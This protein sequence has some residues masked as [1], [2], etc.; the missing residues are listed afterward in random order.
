VPRITSTESLADAT[1]II[2]AVF[3]NVE[4]E[5][6]SVFKLGAEILGL[7][8]EES[9]K[10]EDV[11]RLALVCSFFRDTLQRLP[12]LF[13]AVCI[14]TRPQNSRPPSSV[15][16]LY[17]YSIR[18]S[19]HLSA[20][21]E[22]TMKVSLAVMINF[23]SPD[24][25]DE[26]DEEQ[27]R[28]DALSMLSILCRHSDRWETLVI[29][30]VGLF[31]PD[32]LDWQKMLPGPLGNLKRLSLRNNI[33]PMMES[34]KHWLPQIRVLHV[35]PLDKD[36]LETLSEAPWLLNIHDLILKCD[37]DASITSSTRKLLHA[38]HTLRS[39]HIDGARGI[40]N[41]FKVVTLNSL[42]ELTLNG[43]FPLTRLQA[44]A[45]TSLT[46]NDKVWL[47]RYDPDFPDSPYPCLRRLSIVSKDP[48]MFIKNIQSYD[49]LFLDFLDYDNSY[50]RNWT[51]AAS[52]I[53]ARAVTIHR[54]RFPEA[55]F[56]SMLQVMSGVLEEL[57]LVDVRINS[58][59]IDLFSKRDRCVQTIREFRF[60]NRQHQRWIWTPLVGWVFLG[61]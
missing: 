11:L 49:S 29:E 44:P 31:K 52:G 47:D 33:L 54:A 3:V 30:D 25:D 24:N 2:Q 32:E 48:Q 53:T 36:Q 6:P 45:L 34:M 18:S 35:Q 41:T 55:T 50:E 22:C 7:I 51:E 17:F 8:F 39:L 56:I 43:A 58:N 37:D 28:K 59:F 19:D 16:G 57:E 61:M 26:S 21:L 42:T 40:R 38:C 12:R 5:R 9:A 46:V 14:T 13:S 1:F 23:P 4:C 15:F 20:L 10:K 60:R 27:K